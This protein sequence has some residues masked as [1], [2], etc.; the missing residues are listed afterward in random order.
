MP[1]FANFVQKE[2]ST[3]ILDK[4]GIGE[5]EASPVLLLFFIKLECLSY[6]L[7]KLTFR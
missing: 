6:S 1:I 2:P 5:N 7:V 4:I 3:F